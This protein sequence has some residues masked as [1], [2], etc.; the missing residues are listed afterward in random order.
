MR[1]LAKIS[2]TEEVMIYKK[3]MKK[4]HTVVKEITPL[5]LENITW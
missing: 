1:E 5:D 4:V 3:G 2:E